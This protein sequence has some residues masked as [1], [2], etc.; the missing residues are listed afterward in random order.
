MSYLNSDTKSSWPTTKRI[1]ALTDGIF[2]IAMTLLVLNLSLPPLTQHS[3]Q[4]LLSMLSSQ[5]YDF[6]DYGLSFIL[7]AIFWIIQH[8]QFH[9][10]QHTDTKHLWINIFMLMFV[11]LVPF[12]TSIVGDFG[13]N[14]IADIFFS[15]NIL[16]LG[17][18]FLFNWIYATG[19][20]RLVSHDLEDKIVTRGIV[21]AAVIPMVSLA[22]MITSLFSPYWCLWIFLFIPLSLI[23]R[24]FVKF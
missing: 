10:L 24:P 19:N 3:P 15:G 5:L 20:S 9:Y 17:F 13:K 8:E 18:L 16:I 22:T 21:T 6:L 12:S 14:T 1:E 11:A 2:A 4:I 23:F 7:L